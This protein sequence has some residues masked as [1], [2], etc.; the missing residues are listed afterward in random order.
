M[1]QYPQLKDAV[2]GAQ[3]IQSPASPLGSFP[4]LAQMYQS[5]FQLPQSS[6]ATGVLAQ[7]TNDVVDEQKRQAAAAEAARAAAASSGSRKGGQGYTI[8][9]RKDGGF[10]Y[11]DAD[12]NEV[13]ASDYADATGKDLSTVLKNSKNPIDKAFLQDY[14]QV[15]EYINN[16][17]HAKDDPVAR[18]KAQQVE[19]QVRKLYNIKLHQQTPD[20]LVNAF[21]AA[22]PTIF[23]KGSTYSG[24]YTSGFGD[25]AGRQKTNALL[26]SAASLKQKKTSSS[27]SGFSR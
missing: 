3:S 18:S 16:K 4:E 1:D 22:Y 27:S 17:I 26:P 7:N 20:A 10:G 2:L 12:G 21:M 25:Q 9:A 14:K 19:T 5:T 8:Q 24:G 6:G 23:G 15:N 11:Y 13:S